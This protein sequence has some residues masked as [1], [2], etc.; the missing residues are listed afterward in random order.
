M[1]YSNK[2]I[3]N[4]PSVDVAKLFCVETYFSEKSFGIHAP[5]KWLKTDE[6]SKISE[7]IP[8]L[9]EFIELIYR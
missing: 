7:H 4:K 1:F 9:Y 5:Y 8:E 2:I 3:N 6:L